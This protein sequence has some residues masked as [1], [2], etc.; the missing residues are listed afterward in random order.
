MLSLLPALCAGGLC[1]APVAETPAAEACAAAE[2]VLVVQE[3]GDS[4]RVSVN[5]HEY[6]VA[7][8]ASA[9]EL[10]ATD[11]IAYVVLYA[12]ARARWSSVAQVVQALSD[13][14]IRNI[15]LKK[16]DSRNHH[17]PLSTNY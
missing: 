7:E 11:S 8:L 14:G 10:A 2:L 4:V 5:S 3:I 9:P 6:S 17:S 15:K 13:M 12:D 16:L 1:A